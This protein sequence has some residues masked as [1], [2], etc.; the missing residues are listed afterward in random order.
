L[1]LSRELAD[2]RIFPAI[3]I[4]QSATRREELLLSAEA[5][6]LSRANVGP[7]DAMAELLGVM[8]RTRTNAELLELSRAG[9]G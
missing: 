4:I 1:I 9:R 7:A 3:D 8:K 5:L 2:K 6:M